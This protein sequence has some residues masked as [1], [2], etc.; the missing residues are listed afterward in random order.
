MITSEIIGITLPT[1]SLWLVYGREIPTR[2]FARCARTSKKEPTNQ[3]SSLARSLKRLNRHKI[4]A[5]RRYNYTAIIINRKKC[6]VV[7]RNRWAGKVAHFRSSVCV[8]V[9]ST[10][11]VIYI[12]ASAYLN[13]NM[14][15]GA[16]FV[17]DWWLICWPYVSATAAYRSATSHLFLKTLFKNK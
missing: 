17:C 8:I 4:N 9:K 10:S 1:S 11:E 7:Y 15:I 6:P 3:S 16:M 13:K 5:S 2:T 12:G 14:Q